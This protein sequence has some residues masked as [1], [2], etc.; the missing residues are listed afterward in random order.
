M[1]TRKILRGEELRDLGRAIAESDIRLYKKLSEM[2]ASV[3]IEIT[4]STIITP[5]MPS[6]V[7][8]GYSQRMK[9]ELALNGEKYLSHE[10]K[11]YKK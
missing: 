7:L 4:Q 1:E 6:E 5:A 3:G 10:K 2:A 9:K 11:D 8:E